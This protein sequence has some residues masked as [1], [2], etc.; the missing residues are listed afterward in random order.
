MQND[1]ASFCSKHLFFIPLIINF[2]CKIFTLV[3]GVPNCQ[4]GPDPRGGLEDRGAQTGNGSW[5]TEHQDRWCWPAAHH[6]TEECRE[7][8]RSEEEYP[9]GEGVIIILF[10]IIIIIIMRL[11]NESY[12]TT[13]MQ[14]I[15]GDSTIRNPLLR[16]SRRLMRALVFIF[17]KPKSK[18]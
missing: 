5:Q 8:K 1:S 2:F 3:W 14:N 6:K 12:R 9:W 15:S 10:I 4:P 17:V 13:N 18:F 16:R 7:S 11:W